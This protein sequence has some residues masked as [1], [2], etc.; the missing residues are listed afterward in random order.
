VPSY[1][2]IITLS[3]VQLSDEQSQR[4]RP[5]LDQVFG[6]DAT[7]ATWEAGG[8]HYWRVI[9]ILEAPTMLAGAEVLIRMAAEA[10]AAAGL[11]PG[12]AVGLSCLFRDL[13][14]PVDLVLPSENRHP[15]RDGRARTRASAER[16]EL[17]STLDQGES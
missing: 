9:H 11:G 1:G 10:R 16:T 6:R 4:V 13:S 15:S 5:A 2:V 7:T 8:Y 3:D 12:Q 17:G 14:H